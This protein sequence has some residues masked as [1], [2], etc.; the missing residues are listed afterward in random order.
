MPNTKHPHLNYPK[1]KG[2]ATTEWINWLIVE[3]NFNNLT[4]RYSWRDFVITTAIKN[5]LFF[6][7]VFLLERK[8]S[9]YFVLFSKKNQYLLT[10]KYNLDSNWWMGLTDEH[11]DGTWIWYDTLQEA[12]FNGDY[13]LYYLYSVA[14]I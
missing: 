7:F 13:E 5:T 12:E 3:Y 9:Y 14:I 6:K 11:I 1:P 2:Q 10:L 4:L 8:R